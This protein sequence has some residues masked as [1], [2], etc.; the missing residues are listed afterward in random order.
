MT[1]WWAK[2]NGRLVKRNQQGII[3]VAEYD[4][5]PLVIL[6]AAQL[7]KEGKNATE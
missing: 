1:E 3:A 2:E 6:F 5:L 4:E 7:L